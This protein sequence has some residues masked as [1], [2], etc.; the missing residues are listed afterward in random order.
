MS[1]RAKVEPRDISEENAARRMGLTL[2]QFETC[3]FALFD[4][5][6]PPPDQTTGLFDLDA[7][8]QW[9]KLRNPHLFDLQLLT[10]APRLRDAREKLRG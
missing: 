10:G 1:R 6:F 7:I 5:G 9:R 3:K 8:D 2:A 4:R